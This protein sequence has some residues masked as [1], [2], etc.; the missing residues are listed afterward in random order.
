MISRIYIGKSCRVRRG[1][2]D[3]RAR[4][5][6]VF[7]VYLAAAADVQL[8]QNPLQGVMP[9]AARTGA[10]TTPTGSQA[11]RRSTP[12][13]DPARRHR[14]LPPPVHSRTVTSSR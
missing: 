7:L 12:P 8:S 2:G 5:A 13:D 3:S 9:A 4:P 10:G 6:P 14:W 11:M 1:P